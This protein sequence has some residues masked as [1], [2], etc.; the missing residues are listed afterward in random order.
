HLA[1]RIIGG[2][3]FEKSW[4]VGEPGMSRKDTEELQILLTRR[5]FD[6]GGSDGKA[7]PKTR[8]AIRA[9]QSAAGIPADGFPSQA[10]LQ[11]VR[12]Q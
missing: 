11:M 4:P 1:D 12:G 3:P 8:A 6:T 7:G 2:G 9:F 5:G 10:L